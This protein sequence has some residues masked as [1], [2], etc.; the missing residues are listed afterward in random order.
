MGSLT[1][2]AIGQVK[3]LRTRGN[4]ISGEDSNLARLEAFLLRAELESRSRLL[5]AIPT[6][7]RALHQSVKPFH[8]ELLFSLAELAWQVGQQGGQ[9]D[10][11]GCDL[12]T[13]SVSRGF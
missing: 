5:N 12:R 6:S 4:V 3:P 8:K 7:S 2:S 10:R 1:T 13:G 9:R 11:V